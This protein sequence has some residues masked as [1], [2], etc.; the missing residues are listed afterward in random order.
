MNLI[1]VVVCEAGWCLTSL[2]YILYQHVRGPRL[3]PM[4]VI[5]TAVQVLNNFVLGRYHPAWDRTNKL[6]FKR[7]DMSA[8][9]QVCLIFFLS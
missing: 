2:L 5:A 8:F 9:C 1:K 6:S 4:S 7:A 3:L